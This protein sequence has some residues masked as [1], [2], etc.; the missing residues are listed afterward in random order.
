MSK[1]IAT[2]V[3]ALPT[4]FVSMSFMSPK[5]ALAG[6]F[7]APVLLVHG[8][9]TGSSINCNWHPEFG[10]VRDFF[11][12]RSYTNLKTAATILAIGI[13]TTISGTVMR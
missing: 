4:I 6:S 11:T 8:I 3:V 1:R 12:A 13:V 5:P 2:L 10:T 7:N 9:N